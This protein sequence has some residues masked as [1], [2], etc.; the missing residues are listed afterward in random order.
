MRIKIEAEPIGPLRVLPDLPDARLAILEG[1][2]GIGKTLAVRLIQICTTGASPYRAES[3]AW[4][5]L[6]NGLG[7]FRIQISDLKGGATVEWAAD[8][9]KWSGKDDV[10]HSFERILINGKTSTIREVR[11]LLVVHRLA[12]DETLIETL[13][14]QADS[15]ESV[16]RRWMSAVASA[17]DGP[18]ARLEGLAGTV[19][20]MLG[21]WSAE[22]YS[23]LLRDMHAAQ[24]SATEASNST[25]AASN[26]LRKLADALELQRRLDQL[27]HTAPDLRQ[28]LQAVD[29]KITT[30]R[31]ELERLQ[32]RIV[33]LAEHAA[34]RQPVLKELRNAQR[35]L[36]RNQDK[37]SSVLNTARTAAAQIELALTR[38]ALQ[39]AAFK[40]GQQIEDLTN[41]QIS[42]DAAPAMRVLLD[43]VSSRLLDGEGRGLADQVA[44]EDPETD[45]QLTVAETRVGMVTR[46]GQLEGQPPP[47]DAKEVAEQLGQAQ[48]QLERVTQLGQ[49][50][51]SV[52]RYRRLVATN[53]QRVDQALSAANPRA[54]AELQSLE[55]RRR[56]LD[57]A[58]LELAADRAVLRQQLG[59]LGGE[60]PEVVESRLTAVLKQLGSA[61]DALAAAIEDARESERKARLRVEETRQRFATLRRD[62]ARAE[63]DVKRTTRNL[64]PSGDLRWVQVAAGLPSVLSDGARLEEQL[65]PIDRVRARVAATIERLG[66]HRTQLGA[67]G[68]ALRGIGR[69]LRGQ[70]PEAVEYVAELEKWFGSRFS[71]W[72]NSEKVR[73]ELLPEADD[74]ISVHVSQREVRWLEKGRGRSRP[75]EAF[76]SGEQAFAYTRAR[77][78][79]LDQNAAKAPNRLIVLDEFGAFIAH[80]RLSGLLS[81]LQERV[82]DHP[83]DQVLVILPLSHDYVSEARSSVGSEKE[84]L[85][86]LAKQIESRG[87]AVRVLAT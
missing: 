45:L 36:R 15:A 55:T 57:N 16:V 65:L 78:A 26:R 30:T 86:R 64:G 76:S 25:E 63:A 81:Y 56:E 46:R 31:G 10:S 75:L 71:E 39:A 69:Q 62:V 66:I 58:L 41:R 82:K 87:C 3:P 79:I 72:F 47:P 13:A 34:R 21:E 7:A 83:N 52:D 22:R 77:L 18:I 2:N 4:V 27:R 23:E 14:Q 6:C 32:N 68:A 42:M 51:D 85:E 61:P 19:L 8:T 54:L 43:E 84:N 59:N 35:T 1:L 20:K 12:G 48:G 28:R 38:E 33:A 40:L 5:S 80:D 37:L 11:H 17:A 44:L 70:D 60:A 73:K 24:T 67:I 29:E 49:Y 9:R 50:V 53:E 74:R